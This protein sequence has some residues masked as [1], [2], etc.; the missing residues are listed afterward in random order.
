MA[1]GRPADR[2]RG[3]Q[4]APA[5]QEGGE[6]AEGDPQAAAARR[7]R[8]DRERVRRRARGRADLRL[9]LRDLRRRQAGRA[10]L[11]QLDD[12]DG[13]QGGLREPAPRRAAAPAR[14]G[15]A[16]PLRGRLARRHER[17]PRRH[18]PRPRLG[19]RGRLARPRADA[20]AG[21]DGQA[22]A[23]DPGLRA[24]ALLA[25]PRA[26]RPTLRGPLVRGRRD[27]ARRTASAPRRSRR[28]SPA[29]TASSS[30]SSA[31]S[32]PSARRSSTTSPRCSATRTAASASPRAARCRPR[33]RSTR[34]RRRSP[35]RERAHAGSP[36]TSS[37]S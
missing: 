23:R 24:R 17:D 29:R 28:R 26:V 31:R 16:L 14:G 10:A 6:A 37:R 33:S 36:A 9:H 19:R 11:D 1:H 30:R 34:T 18:D 3:V 32:S 5:R 12:E 13:D 35:T 7:R 22:R 8:P 15:R 21:A 25:G 4:A 2:A 20:D 27:A